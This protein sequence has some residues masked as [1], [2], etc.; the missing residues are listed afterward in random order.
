MNRRER[1]HTEKQLGLNKF[2]KKMTR[3]QRFKKMQENQEN[4]R[5]MQEEF[6]KNVEISLQAQHD[7]KQSDIIAHK[8]EDISKRKNIPVID[9]MVEAQEEYNNSNK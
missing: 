5:R 6:K 9:A 3:E 1:R 7:Q 8:A 4:G 2:Y